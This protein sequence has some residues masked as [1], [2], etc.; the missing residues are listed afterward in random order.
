[1]AKARRRGSV[2]LLGVTRRRRPAL[3]VSTALC[4]TV[5]IV[6]SLPAQAQLAPNAMPTGG[7]V[8]GGS[9]SISQGAN[10]TTIN[11]A[12]QRAAINWQ[13]F[14]IGSQA[15]V[16]FNQPNAAAVALNRVTTPNPSQIAGKLDANG[17]V[18]IENQ[19]GVIFYRGSQ[20][21]TAG[22]MVSAASSSDAATRAFLNGGK[23]VTDLAAN[24]NAAVINQGQI[25]VRQAGLAALVAPQVRNDGVIVARLGHV[26]LASG[27]ETTLD[28][29]GDGLM[30]IDVT[31][32]VKTLPNGATALVTNT[33]VII[34]DGGT[35]QLTARE[36]DG[37][38]Q[39]LVDAGGKIRANTIGSHVG[40]ITLAGVGGNITIEGQLQADGVAP[41]TS[42][43]N[44]VVNPSGNVNVAATARI[45]ASGDAGGGVIALG[46]TLKRAKGGPGVN[47]KHTSAGVYI[48][49][50]AQIAADATRKGNGGR[51]TVLSTGTTVM[52]GT[53]SA[54]GGTL[55]GNGGFVEISGNVLGMTVGSV[56][57]S[58]T[59]G[60]IGTILL[61]PRDLDIVANGAN[62]ADK[63]S[64]GVDVGSPDQNTDIT[65]S[66]S[67]LTALTG[68]L[69]IEASRNLTI[70]TPLLF[71]KQTAANSSVDFL[72]GNNL[73]V[74]QSVST[75]GG[76]LLLSAATQ[77]DGVT[78]FNHFSAAGS[79]TVN[80]AVGSAT[81]GTVSLSGGTGGIT[82]NANVASGSTVNLTSAGTI[83]Q[84][85]GSISATTLSGSSVRG[86]TLTSTNAVGTLA[87]FSDTG[88][89]NTTG[90]SF[91]NGQALTV[92]GVSSTGPIALKTTGNGSNITL[93]G[94]VS[95][96]GTTVALIS[97][98]TIGQTGGSI[99]AA[100][101][102]GS[103]VG[104]ATLTGTNAVG[105]LANFSDT[106]G[107]N[108]TGLS[109]TNG[110]ALTVNGVS[111]T[112]PIALTTT[113]TGS[114]MTLAGNVTASG[115]TVALVS[116]GTIGQTGGSITAATLTGS[117]AA[118]VSLLG[119]NAVANLGNFPVASGNFF[120][121]D[122]SA[123]NVTGVVSVAAS[124]GEIYLESSNSGGI[125]I[126]NGGSVL[127]TND[128]E[129]T[130][131]TNAFT[132]A[133]GGSV[134]T[135]FYVG[136]APDTIGG[137]M[138]LGTLVSGELSL[139]SLSGLTTGN[140]RIGAVT[141]PGQMIGSGVANAGSIAIGGTFDT[142][143]L[144]TLSFYTTGGGSVTQTQPIIGGAQLGGVVSGSLTLLNPNNAIGGLA[145]LSA[146]GNIEALDQSALALTAVSSSGGNV[147]AAS[148]NASGVTLNGNVSAAGT[149]GVQADALTFTSGTISAPTVELAPFHSGTLVTLG[150]SGGLSLANLSHIAASALL[151][152]GAI[153]IP[154]TAGLTTTAGTIVIADA[155][156]NSSTA[157]EL[158]SLGSISGSTGVLTASTLSGSAAGT[159]NLTA[160]N[161]IGS[162]G[163][164]TVTGGDFDLNN[165]GT[166][167]V[168]GA[169]SAANATINAGAIT[170]SSGSIL[171]PSGTVNLSTS[172]G[173]IALNGSALLNGGTVALASKTSITEATTATIVAG[174]LGA[175]ASGGTIQ[176]GSPLNIISTVNGIS[177]PG[178]NITLVSD[179]NLLLTGTYTG[180]NMLYEVTGST[181]VLQIGSAAVGAT[182]N[183]T[184]TISLVADN[185]TESTSSTL[186]ALSG[187]VEIAP[188]TGTSVTLN[189]TQGAS[190]LVI[191]STLL[192]EINSPLLRVGQAL[193]TTSATGIT[194]ANALN[195]GTV[196]LELDSTGSVVASGTNA[197]TTPTLSGSAAAGFTLI[198][199]GNSIF[200]LG[201]LTA[202]S[203]DILVAD[204]AA[205]SVA[206][207]VTASTGNIEVKQAPS[208]GLTFN[209][210]SLI[211]GGSG[212]IGVV[213]DSLTFNSGSIATGSGGLV[214][215]AP[216][217]SAIAV[218]LGTSSSTG[219]LGVTTTA[220]AAINT[221]NGTLRIGGYHDRIDN[222][223]AFT[224]TAGSIGIVAALALTSA[225]QD[226][227]LNATAGISQASGDGIT[228]GTL[229]GTAT[230]GNVV[231]D[232]PTNTI[233]TLGAFTVSAGTLSLVNN[234]ADALRV[235]GP[236]TATG[237]A[238]QS[239]ALVI[240]G[241][242]TATSSGSIDLVNGAASPMLLQGGGLNTAGV[243]QLDSKDGINETGGTINAGILQSS[244]FVT[245]PTGVS[246]ANSNTIGTL[247]NFGVTG[248]GFTLN[249]TGSGTGLSVP[250]TVTATNVALTIGAGTLA[251]GG[252]IS[253]SSGSIALAGTS[254][255][256]TIALNGTAI[257]SG[258]TVTLN[259]GTI[260]LNGSSSVGSTTGLVDLTATSGGVNEAST[261]TIVAATLQ[262]SGNVAAGATLAGVANN[263]G[264]LGTFIVTSG[265][266]DLIDPLAA[267]LAVNGS[268][269]AAGVTITGPGTI[270]VGA[271][272]NSTTGTLLLNGGS[273]VIATSGVLSDP[274]GAVDLSTTAGGITE[275][276]GSIVAAVLQSASNAAG[277][278]TLGD[279][280]NVGTLAGFV[281]NS[282]SLLLADGNSNNLSV[283]GSVSAAGVTL[284][285]GTIA[286]SN[287][288]VSTGSLGL[289]ATA[290]GISI[291]SLASA[292]GT[293]DLSAASGVVTELN[294]GTIVAATLVSSQGVG[295]GATLL[296]NTNGIGSLGQFT[297]TNGPFLLVDA[298][299][300][301]IAAPVSAHNTIFV[302]DLA[303]G[304]ITLAAGGAL[305]A[306]AAPLIELVADQ[307]VTDP[308]FGT[309]GA[310]GGAVAIA[311]FTGGTPIS[312]AGSAGNAGTLLIAGSLLADIYAGT[313]TLQIGSYSDIANNGNG[314]VTAG[315]ISVDGVVSLN[316]HA[317][318]LRIDSNSGSIV[319]SGGN[320][321]QVGTLIG[322]AAGGATLTNSNT[323]A[324]LAGFIASNG[325]F[326]LNDAGESAGTFDVTG[327]VSANNVTMTGAGGDTIVAG[328]TATSGNIQ[329]SGGSIALGTNGLLQA[330]TGT[331]DLDS[332]A[333]GI[334]ESGGGSI[335]AA[336][337]LSS[338]GA[339]GNVDLASANAIG[340]LGSFVVT[341]GTFH[342]SNS[343][344]LSGLNVTGSVIAS[345]VT[346]DGLSGTLAVSNTIAATAA[347]GLVS[348]TDTGTGGNIALNTGAVVTGPTIDLKTGSIALNGNA[349]L[350]NTAALVDLTATSGGVTEATTATL[351]AATLQ[352][353]GGIANSVSLG[354]T[355][356]TIAAIGSLAVNSG[357]FALA[358]NGNLNVG[359]LTAP[360][361]GITDSNGTLTVTHS[362]IATHAVSLTAVTIL[363]P[364]EVS[365]GGSGT[366]NLVATTGS[367]IETGTLIA[368]TL[369][370]SAAAMAMFGTST[371]ANQ[372][373]NVSSFNAGTFV[374]NDG[375]A[376]NVGSI[377]GGAF[378]S[379]DVAGSLTINTLVSASTIGLTATSINIPGL[380]NA[381]TSGPL[382]L[383]ATTGSI[384]ETGTI[385]AGTLT[386]SAVTAANLAGFVNGSVFANQVGTLGN[387][388]AAG[389]VLN[390]G[391]A[392]TV[393]GLVNG[394]SNVAIDTSQSLS[395]TG[396]VLSTSLVSLTGSAIAI[397]GT[398]LVSDGGSG[399]TDIVATNGT[400]F[401]NAAL[402]AGT[403]NG[404]ATGA[405]S[406]SGSNTI[407]SVGS[408]GAN[409]FVLNDGT[410]ALNIGTVMG[411]TL[412]SIDVTGT[413]TIAHVVS[414]TSVDLDATTILIPGTVNAT[415]AG[416]VDLI[417]NGGSINE[418]G[419]LIAAM[420]S[421]SATGVADLLG[422]TSTTNQIGTVVSFTS[423][424]FALDDGTN[425]TIQAVSATSF[426]T[427]LDA[428]T[429]T[430]SG[431]LSATAIGLSAGSITIPGEVNAGLGGTINLAGTTGAITETGTLIAGTLSGTAALAADFFGASASANQILNVGSFGSA[432]FVLNDGTA[433]TAGV[434]NSGTLASIDVAGTL[435]LNTLVG[436]GIVDLTATTIVVPGTVTAGTSGTADLIAS[437]GS[438]SVTG[439]LI[440]GTVL[441]SSVGTTDIAN[442]MIGTLGSFSAST[443]VLND[444]T[445]LTVI[446]PVIASSGSVAIAVT[447]TL[448]NNSTVQAA[449]AATLSSTGNFTNAGSIIAGNGD[450]SLAASTG[451]LLNSGL[452]LA[453]N[454]ATLSAG[455]DLTNGGSI[456]AQAGSVSLTATGTL[457]NSVLISAATNAT[458][459]GGTSF[460]NTGTVM[461]GGNAA[462]TA[463][464]DLTN[465][466]TGS[467]IANGGNASLTA[468]AGTLT[469][470]GLV[471]A[472]ANTTLTA[473]TSLT[474]GGSVFANGGSVLIAANAGTLANN[475]GLIQASTST[476]LTA[477]TDLINS[478]SV[479]AQTGN[480]LLTASI[481]TL[482][483]AGSITAGSTI[484]ATASAGPIVQ[485]SGASMVAAT[486]VA[487]NAAGSGG[488]TL[489]GV[490]DG[491]A[492]VSLQSG[493]TINQNGSLIAPILT[494][495]AASTVNLLGS[496]ATANQVATL[497]SF[498]ARGFTLRDGEALDVTGPVNGGPS[499]SI[500]DAAA[501]TVDGNVISTAAVSL[502]GSSVT[503]N[504]DGYVSDGGAGTTSLTASAGAITETGTL[505]AGTLSGSATGAASL[506]GASAS[507]NQIANL[508]NF[509]AASLTLQ[510]G[511]SL[512]TVGA[513]T[514]TSGAIAITTQGALTNSS[515]IQAATSAT[516]TA[517]TGV[518]NTASGS[519]VAQGGVASL[520]ASGG[521]L[522]NN[523]LIQASTSTTLT[524]ATTVTNTGSD[525]ARTG[526]ATV[527][528]SGGAMSNS[529]L[530][531][532]S[533]NTTVNA[534][535]NLSNAG[536]VVAQ[537]GNASLTASNGTLS[538]SGVMSAGET[539][540]LT[541][542]HGSLIQSGSGASMSAGARI[543]TNAA[544]NISLDGVVKDDTGVSLTAGG[545]IFQDGVLI[546]DLLTGSA[547]GTVN[548]AGATVTSN[549]VADLGNFTANGG[550]FILH[551]G[552]NL[553]I[554]GVVTAATIQI[555]D[556]G[557]ITLGNGS[558]VTGGAVRPSMALTTSQLPTAATTQGAY[559]T[560]G[561]VVE[562][563]GF[564]VS[565]LPG[566]QESIISIALGNGAGSVQFG[567]SGLFAPNTWMI[568]SV[569]N[570]T[571]SGSFN[572]EALDF[573]YIQPGG[574]ATFI[575]A[576][577]AGLSGNAAAGAAFI[578][579]QPNTNFRI[580]GCPIHSVNC[581]ILTTQTLPQA[582]PV[583]D[584]IVGAP[585]NSQNPED[586]VLPVV[587]DERYELLP[588]VSPDAQ[589]AC[590]DGKR[591][592]R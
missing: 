572:V 237:I 249:D 172:T 6:V 548:L 147:Y 547:G 405:A 311:P 262:S 231:L 435:T 166:L 212:T 125:T 338:T 335:I 143:G 473:G 175:S 481:G 194:V 371:A 337:L 110:Q 506:T 542:P 556:P 589:G 216:R 509:S 376:L 177:A 201:Q 137:S 189:G 413:L 381:G 27:T 168:T 86:A 399:T 217:S 210:G 350:G 412:A 183:A 591:A 256:S 228:I 299:S 492:S 131:Q 272:I 526:S 418:T 154:G 303:A 592:A 573:I 551:D 261:A 375:V 482:T 571:A 251:V 190:G 26:V 200:A 368:G 478:G 537:A 327:L 554:N 326:T 118:T 557:Q 343:G 180:A 13:T 158:D 181:D 179:P 9:A 64:T 379:I 296:N 437:P 587:S 349:V 329:V 252:T 136:L 325:S 490:V 534:A 46:T 579:P 442:S 253:S 531:Q 186:V 588:C 386:G 467:V 236:V 500:V 536:S 344:S 565:N 48:A 59:A 33:G 34:A 521:A 16:Q 178:N 447:G 219:T 444:G 560:A 209:G 578:Q 289:T 271:G 283:T 317:N 247:A 332:T 558:F 503:I 568:L 519:V 409:G 198:A 213:T 160:T 583:S 139:V 233:G 358:D 333:G 290:G 377:N 402:V 11:Q 411:G 227:D 51:V 314:T 294:G 132:I 4:A 266:F 58:A 513:V 10:Q 365:D 436:N 242:L 221:G 546:A 202:G 85:A 514:S 382:S 61:D 142:T 416:S 25:T 245:G 250:G 569:G 517:G 304:G 321:I 273:I 54:T 385:I 74:N 72:A 533:T 30:S 43:G 414:A 164:F 494:G 211:V 430:V 174:T 313:G 374:M 275:T 505:V 65:V 518:T 14:N 357:T 225:A 383:I 417:A 258:A 470:N 101:L 229:T 115:N 75:G 397:T 466:N 57:L 355:G 18:I 539:L 351:L 22:L 345:S 352:S 393:A 559:L 576:S 562:S 223:G 187:A 331:V 71:S 21:N 254:A 448:T 90:L 82:L 203:G 63:G 55:G 523:G 197:L 342:L 49:P 235:T 243:V 431:S 259:A 60:T 561:S 433:L 480:V 167:A 498:T 363:I 68:N 149:V 293:L 586:L 489:N 226:L 45:S 584:I 240:E 462:V 184:G 103:S 334:A 404:S 510:D 50:G 302:K 392:L 421:G 370:G 410:T 156:G 100:T 443:F 263:V 150:G 426:A 449:T 176:L 32:L 286:T 83:S 207:A 535:T 582:S 336:T 310:V 319:E 488:A 362:L 80:A 119:A 552:A 570:G 15:K 423:N 37:I 185:I 199:A 451:S 389:F 114:N 469:N 92:N 170:L 169:V 328:V 419:T 291:A 248:A 455:I 438:I 38:V 330:T 493:G 270:N 384:N 527:T 76:S 297:V 390:T 504:G 98:G 79:L 204:A 155:F 17:Q 87:N 195:T 102:G 315:N 84:T 288:I 7:S 312:L 541:S 380:V 306:S 39:T 94:S 230:A 165:G 208:T 133:A 406:F 257:V 104:G 396:S 109:F 53:I 580:D 20:V 159:V 359:T 127:A 479:G 318:T 138:S 512:A 97:A 524:A 530:I 260:G 66:G 452:V 77:T 522:S 563:G 590:D 508:S 581:T 120:L 220:L 107:S 525:I 364:G 476:T 232:E 528:A 346:L 129:A 152:I 116:A 515:A 457:A 495:S 549:Q 532:A 145:N 173:A 264:T 486:R 134:A 298:Q 265:T 497:A 347:G 117:A 555:T 255:A 308:S 516:L 234:A 128:G 105:T 93:A 24:P 205:L 496:T 305:T 106:G 41:G 241:N 507:T 366:T 5:A 282:G 1:M 499:A 284:V 19:S 44:I 224:I 520:T 295:N 67:V 369:S 372:I 407:A 309:I 450:A 564:S 276:G 574:Q 121:M 484:A 348:L 123:L 29:Y 320:S 246:L 277:A 268:V 292:G 300:L 274:T 141:T 153:S 453:S 215:I 42:G 420:L 135:G 544:G 567:G 322:T 456:I 285:A 425:L 553:L 474:N 56:G 538:N 301:S 146:S 222:A 163:T 8:F 485:T 69:Q 191:D 339:N 78:S 387:F 391:T 196:S 502:T 340:T 398:A 415:P 89:G 432:G 543:I 214:E 62:D 95:A 99:T 267:N 140:L 182:L 458:L 360:T 188:S 130:F 281:V 3:L 577:V 192:S 408:F 151:R 31:G 23:L 238:L 193:G 429:L 206:G 113:G 434:I 440:A 585:G 403:L 566:T 511:V 144:P 461:A 529:G 356:N 468:T 445:S 88:S 545:N 575:N 428:G 162:L 395:V 427:V 269:S 161:S 35:V 280:N 454:N 463:G 108:T 171:A 373:A 491:G 81:T 126:A 122:T 52:D 400:I 40:K 550:S 367:I 244:T 501:L 475:G 378:A 472:S 2:K 341:S 401:E 157:L 218:V 439:T 70:D 148:S 324:T 388:S 12:S 422:A 307:L 323:I 441:G 465:A 361:I 316:G 112:G 354:G 28:L 483:N 424:G 279:T 353:S 459:A 36:A 487:L 446:A 124:Q 287:S 111:S 394:G 540:T 91:T 278:V 47:A 96:S 239:G 460:G 73:I 471:K 477:S 464:T